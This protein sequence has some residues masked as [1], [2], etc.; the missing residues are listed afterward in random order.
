[1][2][3]QFPIIENRLEN[4]IQEPIWTQQLPSP[5]ALPDD[6]TGINFHSTGWDNT[7]ELSSPPLL[8]SVLTVMLLT[9]TIQATLFLVKLIPLLQPLVYLLLIHTDLKSQTES[10]CKF[11]ILY[12]CIFVQFG[13]FQLG[14][15]RWNCDP[16]SLHHGNHRQ[17]KQGCWWN[18][19]HLHWFDHRCRWHVFRTQLRF[20]TQPCS[21]L[22]PKVRCNHTFVIHF[23]TIFRV[24]T[25]MV[26]GGDVFSAHDF[27]FWIP[28][29]GPY[30]GGAL[31]GLLY[32]HTVEVFSKRLMA[33]VMIHII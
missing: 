23:T 16:R 9:T 18:R 30:V 2:L 10:V 13:F 24:F 20:F 29:I 21:W 8:F 5:S 25:A 26:Y 7:W 12:Y 28:V 14:S 22:W 15:S 31:A 6:L 19:P 27:Y 4:F 32:K 17:E 33:T 11:F 1:M 3:V